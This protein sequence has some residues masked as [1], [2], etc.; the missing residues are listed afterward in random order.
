MAK[1][2][3]QRRGTTAEHN[4]FTGAV[5]EL[6]VDTSKDTVVVHEGSTVG[7]IPLA[8]EAN[9][10]GKILSV[11][12]SADLNM[13]HD[14]SNSY[15]NN[16]SGNL[17]IQQRAISSLI[18]IKSKSSSAATKDGVTIGGATP[19]VKLH[20]N[21][22]V[23]C[24]T[25]SGGI[26]FGTDTAASNT[27]DD[28]EEGTWTPVISDAA[29]GGN[30]A[31]STFGSFFQYVK[32]GKQVTIQCNVSNI[33]ITGMTATNVLHIQGLPFV[34]D[35]ASYTYTQSSSLRC[36]NIA[37]VTGVPI[38]TVKSGVAYITLIDQVANT[39][40]NDV[41]VG[42]LHPTASDLYF[43]ITYNT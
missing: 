7:G 22:A 28:Y 12:T 6:T 37:N 26:A 14:G 15:I 43:T 13:V 21:G 11:G 5:G 32:I 24:S 41:L 10:D 30:V 39:N 3:Q 19:N 36:S 29:T 35:T 33:D 25:Q 4:S 1:Q 20:Y 34:R 18:T 23:A 17:V 31:A 40:P 27:L 16:D 9:V 42:D 38:A 2:V 8:T